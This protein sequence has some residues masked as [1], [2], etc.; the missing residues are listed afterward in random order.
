MAREPVPR[1]E[2]LSGSTRLEHR[3][4]DPLCKAT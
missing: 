1:P 2:G 3:T 4:P